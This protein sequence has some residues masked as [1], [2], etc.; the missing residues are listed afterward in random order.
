MPE[1]PDIRPAFQAFL[2]SQL[3]R[4]PPA[5]VIL[6]ADHARLA[7]EIAANLAAGAFG[8]LPPDVL[9]AIAQHDIGWDV[10]DRNQIL[11]ILETPLRPFPQLSPAEWFPAWEESIRRAEESSPLKGIIVSR[12]FC[13]LTAQ[14]PTH[15]WFAE[16]EIPRR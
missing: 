7:G 14:D 15:R 4:K 16:Q 12:H 10:S 8:D 13:A 2:E 9:E 1:K 3:E 5:A 11:H 6:Q